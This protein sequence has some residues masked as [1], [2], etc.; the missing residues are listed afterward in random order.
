MLGWGQQLLSSLTRLTRCRY[1]HNRYGLC[2]D[3]RWL[4]RVPSPPRSLRGG[5]PSRLVAAVVLK[6]INI[7]GRRNISDL[8]VL[9]AL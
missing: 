1:R 4:G 6:L 2:P 7:A 3:L 8:N 9:Q 5:L